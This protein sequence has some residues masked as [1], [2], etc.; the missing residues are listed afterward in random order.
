M[1]FKIF[2]KALFL[3]SLKTSSETGVDLLHQI[4][5]CQKPALRYFQ[6]KFIIST[7]WLHLP[8]ARKRVS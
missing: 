1:N 6:L 7:G 8:K 4:G 3:P 2:K 5:P